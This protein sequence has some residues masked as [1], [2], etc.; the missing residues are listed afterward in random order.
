MEC[1]VGDSSKIE[2]QI[3][4]LRCFAAVAF[5]VR[6]AP[7]KAS[8]W[9]GNQPLPINSQKQKPQDATSHI[10]RLLKSDFYDFPTVCH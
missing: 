6:P 4:F 7:W 2:L 5:L 9:N 3:F 1:K 10:L 8:T